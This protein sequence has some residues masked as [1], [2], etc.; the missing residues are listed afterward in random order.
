MSLGAGGLLI[1]FLTPSSPLSGFFTQPTAR[2][3][4]QAIIELPLP[5]SANVL[6]EWSL[7]LQINVNAESKFTQPI[8]CRSYAQLLS[9]HLPSVEY[10]KYNN[11]KLNLPGYR[12]RNGGKHGSR[13]RQLDPES[14]SPEVPEEILH[15]QRLLLHNCDR[16]KL[17]VSRY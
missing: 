8:L 12:P 16:L 2:L 15:Q 4:N 6:Y 14:P 5:F 7:K 13:V 11:L 9:S 17:S 10:N 1:I 3:Q